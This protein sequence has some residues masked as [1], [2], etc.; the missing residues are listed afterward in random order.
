MKFER[1]TVKALL[2]FEGADMFGQDGDETFSCSDPIES[3][4]QVLECINEYNQDI[5]AWLKEPDISITIGAYRREKVS[6][7]WIANQAENAAEF[8][9]EN[10]CEE[11]GDLDGEDRLSDADAKELEKRMHEVV[12]W[13]I[14]KA[15][16]FVCE[17]M[18]SFVLDSDDL[19]ELVQQLHPEWL[20]AK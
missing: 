6:D 4:A 15:K 16:V 13:Y 20:E 14:T 1:P 10:F 7:L 11:H 19:L 2:E 18:E 5:R 9:R 17:H 12:S 8:I 3:V